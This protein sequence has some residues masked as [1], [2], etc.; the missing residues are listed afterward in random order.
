MNLVLLTECWAALQYLRK[1]GGENERM[2]ATKK[3]KK[4]SKIAELGIPAR[5]TIIISKIT[6][7]QVISVK[8]WLERYCV[9]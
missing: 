7:I 1:A 3:K 6:S 8:L 9:I 4:R 5:A 2:Q